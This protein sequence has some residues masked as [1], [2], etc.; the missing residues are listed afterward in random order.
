MQHFKS[1]ADKEVPKKYNAELKK[2]RD[3]AT[4]IGVDKD[5]PVCYEVKAGYNIKKHAPLSG[6][7]YEDFKYLQDWDFEDETQDS[8]VFWIPK[9]LPDSFNKNVKEQKELI[10]DFSDDF[11]SVSLLTGLIL[12]HFE[13]TGEKLCESDYF[14]TSSCLRN[15]GERL[16]LGW[17]GGGRLGCVRW[18]W[19]DDGYRH[20]GLGCF[21][22]GCVPLETCKPDNMPS[23]EQLADA[24]KYLADGLKITKILDRSVGINQILNEPEKDHECEEDIYGNC[25]TCERSMLE[26]PSEKEE[27]GAWKIVRDML[28]N[29]DDLG[30][31][32]TSKCYQEL[33]E[34]VMKQKQKAR[35]ETRD[36]PRGY[37]KWL[38]E[39]ERYGYLKHW[40]DTN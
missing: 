39:G 17:D 2:F 22:W 28:D 32:Q 30:I 40:K 31:Y 3:Y 18:D 14:K 5:A 33:Y 34:F 1:L 23:P 36:T 37:S 13:T 26:E 4:K 15:S 19:G 21:A 24:I 9:I 25:Y 10:K 7:C 35:D 27:W 8:L 16:G 20:D 12:H 38:T 11:G 6:N 29:P